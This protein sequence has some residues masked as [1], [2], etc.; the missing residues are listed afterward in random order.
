[1]TNADTLSVPLLERGG[2]ASVVC[3]YT[4]GLTTCGTPLVGSPL[5]GV[6]SGRC[7]DVP[8]A[9]TANGTQPGRV[10]LQ[11]RRQPAADAT[12]PSSCRS[13]AASASTSRA[14]PRG[15]PVEIW[16][17]N[18]GTNQQWT[19]NTNG[20]VTAASPAVPRRHRGGHRERHGLILWTCNGGANQQWARS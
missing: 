3:P 1:M 9:T 11:R 18:G 4:A 10:G 6:Q 2:F 17:C 7:P 8:N 20:T 13:T 19:L 5:R 14:A 16:D 12:R 15:A